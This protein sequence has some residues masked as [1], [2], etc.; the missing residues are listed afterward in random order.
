MNTKDCNTNFI[1]LLHAEG[2]DRFK[3]G[4]S[5]NPEDRRKKIG[6]QSPFPISLVRSYIVIN[7]HEC[8][9]KLHK[10]FS[11]R[12][13]H[14][15]WFVFES[16]DHAKTL[17]DEFFSNHSS[18]LEAKQSN[19]MIEKSRNEVLLA[20]AIK[21]FMF[22]SSDSQISAYDLLNYLSPKTNMKLDVS[23]IETFFDWFEEFHFGKKIV[24][25]I[26]DHKIVSFLFFKLTQD[27]LKE[28]AQ[29]L[30]RTTN[31]T[32]NLCNTQK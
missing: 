22:Q 20:K 8:E 6:Q 26:D 18:N 14:G 25:N 2:S 29:H 3:I 21:S 19:N 30:E 13:I 4:Y 7:A 9:Q 15:E 1:Y 28:I 23:L 17:L 32:I 5:N 12:R 11:H 27:R 31:P 10:M 16:K 24:K